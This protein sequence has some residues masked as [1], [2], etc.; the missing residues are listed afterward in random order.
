MYCH[1]PSWYCSEGMEIRDTWCPPWPPGSIQTI[2]IT[3][4]ITGGPSV[5]RRC[6]RCQ[7]IRECSLASVEPQIFL[8]RRLH[9]D[10]WSGSVWRTVLTMN[11]RSCSRLSPYLGKLPRN[12]V[13]SERKVKR[14]SCNWSSL[15][16]SRRDCGL[17][18]LRWRLIK[19]KIELTQ[20]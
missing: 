17:W 6:R 1:A 13:I 2:C 9:Y 3:E 5:G 11:G 15:Y 12:C 10:I 20:E 14:I 18:P 8:H 16:S 7:D 19:A 4:L